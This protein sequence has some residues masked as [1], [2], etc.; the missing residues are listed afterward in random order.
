LKAVVYSCCYLASLNPLVPGH[1][2][3]DEYRPDVT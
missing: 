1:N 3:Q 2:K